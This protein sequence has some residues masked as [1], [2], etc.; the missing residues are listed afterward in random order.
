[1][2]FQE[3]IKE[4]TCSDSEKD[5]YILTEMIDDFICEVKTLHPEI[6]NHF[7]RNLQM[8]QHPLR[9][10]ET[11]EYAVSKLKNEDGSVGEHWDFETT[12]KLAD[13]YEIHDKPAFY[14]VLNMIYS[15]LYESGRSDSEYVKDAVKFINDKDAPHDKAERYYRAMNY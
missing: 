1:M 3:I 4:Y 10:R 2:K 13:K 6:V 7:L 15:D 5:M 9:D 8:Y 14:Y 11:A 12:S